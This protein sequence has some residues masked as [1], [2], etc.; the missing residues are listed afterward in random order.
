MSCT[1]QDDRD[2]HV[3]MI[4]SAGRYLYKRNGD[5]DFADGRGF[6]FAYGETYCVEDG[7]DTDWSAKQWAEFLNARLCY[8]DEHGRCE[9]DD[10]NSGSN[11]S[12]SRRNRGYSSSNME[13]EEENYNQNWS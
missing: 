7:A 5:H 1:E 9:G 2:T 6:G 10:Y 3:H 13:E 8:D 12:N 11:G 4:E